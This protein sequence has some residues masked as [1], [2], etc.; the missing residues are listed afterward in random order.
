ML[1][2]AEMNLVAHAAF[3]HLAAMDSI[4]HLRDLLLAI[5]PD[6]AT[7]RD[8]HLKHHNCS[9]LSLLWIHSDTEYT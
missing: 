2:D 6:A 8:T 5:A 3:L 7:N 9:L 4:L 1:R